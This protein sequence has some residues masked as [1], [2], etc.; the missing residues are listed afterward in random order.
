MARHAKYAGLPHRVLGLKCSNYRITLQ[1]AII[2]HYRLQVQVSRLNKVDLLGVLYIFQDRIP[3]VERLRLEEWLSIKE[4]RDSGSIENFILVSRE[5]QY[6]SPTLRDTQPSPSAP[7]AKVVLRECSVCAEDLENAQFPTEPCTDTCEHAITVCTGCR[8]RS[9]NEQI[10][11]RSWDRIAC[12]ECPSLLSFTDVK[13]FASI[14]DFQSYDKKALMSLMREDPNFTHCLGAGCDGGQIHDGGNDQPIMT[15]NSCGVKTCFAHKLPWHTGLTC[16]EYDEQQ[17]QRLEQEAASAQ[18]MQANNL[19]QCPNPKC[20]LRLDK[21]G[22]CDHMTCQHCKFEFCWLCFASYED[23]RKLGNEAHKPTC[24]YYRANPQRVHLLA[25][26]RAEDPERVELTA[27]QVEQR[28]ASVR[29]LAA[30]LRR[31]AANRRR[32]QL[33]E[34]QQAPLNSV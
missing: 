9:L 7:Q 26:T 27:E 3:E 21:I 13:K 19:K 20:G 14:E 1:R 10:A 8:T 25:D 24:N 16:T 34:N 29:Q 32:V 5:G 18:F 12:P 22:G 30:R 11:N 2:R 17:R 28:A 33:M 31:Q 4:N 6:M 23:I 15:C